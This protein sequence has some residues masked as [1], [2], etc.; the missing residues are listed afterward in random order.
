[1]RDTTRLDALKKTIAASEEP[2]TTTDGRSLTLTAT[3]YV[4][5]LTGVTETGAYAL[6]TVAGE[7]VLQFRLSPGD[8]TSRFFRVSTETGEEEISDEQ[9]LTLTEVTVSMNG[10]NLA[11]SQPVVVSRKTKPSKVIR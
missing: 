6:L 8:K 11:G 2:W 7:P 4:S 10:T 9:R 5:S 3:T 1:M